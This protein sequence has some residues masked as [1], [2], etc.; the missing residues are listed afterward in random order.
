MGTFDALL[1]AVAA[2]PSEEM[3]RLLLAD[4]CLGEM[5]SVRLQELVQAKSDLLAYP[6]SKGPMNQPC[7]NPCQAAEDLRQRI[8]DLEDDLLEADLDDAIQAIEVA[9]QQ[10]A[11]AKYP[12]SWQHHERALARR[13][14]GRL[15]GGKW[16]EPVEVSNFTPPRPADEYDR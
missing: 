5:G 1:E 2:N 4:Y 8:R 14:M 11:A 9:F 12:H 7:R 6:L 16:N 15:T 10:A 13:D 3:P